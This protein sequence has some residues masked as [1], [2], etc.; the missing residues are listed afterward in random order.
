M[1]A[2]YCNENKYKLL[3]SL[4]SNRIDKNFSRKKEIKYF[5]K[6]SNNNLFNHKSSFVNSS[7]SIITF[8]MSSNIGVE[9]LAQKIYTIYF[10]IL[11]ISDEKFKN[12]Y[13]INKS[14]FFIPSKINYKEIERKFNKLI[15]E[16][17]YSNNVN[18][19]PY[20]IKFDK[21]NSIFKNELYLDIP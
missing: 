11:S 17:Y 5:K 13:F 6:L 8:T 21:G 18:T 16:I 7:E 14:E 20:F 12:P 3:I 1:L 4:N 15:D 19:I 2:K 10:D 9:L